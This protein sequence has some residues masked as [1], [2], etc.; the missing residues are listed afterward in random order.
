M[1]G[2]G[3]WTIDLFLKAVAKDPGGTPIRLAVQLCDLSIIYLGIFGYG[4]LD[5]SQWAQRL[6]AKN[7]KRVNRN[8]KLAS[9][10]IVLCMHI[11]TA[12]L[13]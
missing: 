1:Q 4:F 7:Y 10:A 8:E 12:D 2:I 6:V 5:R 11:Y 9:S 13:V 3:L